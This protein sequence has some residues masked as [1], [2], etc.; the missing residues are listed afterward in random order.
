MIAVTYPNRVV[1]NVKCS[2]L[3]G[4]SLT[5]TIPVLLPPL[6]PLDVDILANASCTRVGD[7]WNYLSQSIKPSDYFVIPPCAVLQV[8]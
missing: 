1:D 3:E 7:L 2:L 8:I 4:I 5:S 6:E